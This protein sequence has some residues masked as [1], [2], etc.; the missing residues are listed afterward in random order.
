M[1][2]VLFSWQALAT[3]ARL[4]LAAIIALLAL[5]AVLTGAMV[6]LIVVKVVWTELKRREK[7]DE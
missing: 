6:A 1:D 7:K 4:F 2:I 5:G 3:C